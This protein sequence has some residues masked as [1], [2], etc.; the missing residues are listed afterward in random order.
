M[1]C[2]QVARWSPRPQVFGTI[3]VLSPISYQFFWYRSFLSPIPLSRLARWSPGPL[4][5]PILYQ[6]FRDRNFISPIPMSPP[7]C[8]FQPHIICY[9]HHHFQFHS[10]QLSPSSRKFCVTVENIL[11]KIYCEHFWAKSTLMGTMD[12]LVTRWPL[13]L[14]CCGWP[15]TQKALG[16]FIFDRADDT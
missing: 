6:F 12:S 4:L 5:S 15:K 2:Q 11:L 3:P 14:K 7:Q 10:W 8:L 1:T 16:H 9:F 13:T